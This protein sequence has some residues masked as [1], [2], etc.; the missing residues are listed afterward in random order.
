M[1]S[2]RGS[3]EGPCGVHT[4]KAGM[5]LLS[6]RAIFLLYYFEIA[7]GDLN[8]RLALIMC[9]SCSEYALSRKGRVALG[10]PKS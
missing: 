6:S 2:P 3:L 8:Q 7:V 4:S 1:V 10:C 5:S 9:F